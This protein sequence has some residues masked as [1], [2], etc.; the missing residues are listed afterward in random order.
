MYAR[1]GP[2]MFTNEA[3]RL[4]KRV[5]SRSSP[6][7]AGP[8]NNAAGGLYGEH[9]D[10]ALCKPQ[11]HAKQKGAAVPRPFRCFCAPDL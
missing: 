10:F 8:G 11:R 3:A 1:R 4:K 9:T 6:A 2:N 5:S 7:N